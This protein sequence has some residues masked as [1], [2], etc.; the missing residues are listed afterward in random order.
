MQRPIIDFSNCGSEAPLTPPSPRK[1]GARERTAG[2][3]PL[4]SIEYQNQRS[5]IC[6]VS[7]GLSGVPSGTAAR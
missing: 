7:P 6:T 1:R 5:L 2:A 3:R 4:P